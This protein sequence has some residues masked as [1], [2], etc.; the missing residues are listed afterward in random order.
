MKDDKIRSLAMKFLN[1]L[2]DFGFE[3]RMLHDEWISLWFRGKRIAHLGC[4]RK[5]FVIVTETDE[6]WKRF[7]IQSESDYEKMLNMLKDKVKD[8]IS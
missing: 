1:E 3:E 4:K 2:A 5:F 7:R 8:K 6:G